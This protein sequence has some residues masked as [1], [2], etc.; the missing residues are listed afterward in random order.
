LGKLARRARTVVLYVVSIA[1]FVFAAFPVISMVLTSLKP[2]TEIMK[3][4]SSLLDA[5]IPKN[6]TL[7]AYERVLFEGT[8][9]FGVYYNAEFP[10]WALH[11]LIVATCVT[12]ITMVATIFGGYGFARFNFR[13][14]GSLK[15][16]ILMFYLLPEVVL[17]VPLFIMLRYLGILNTYYAMIFTY[18]SNCI[19]LAMWLLI[20]FFI[21][22]PVELEEAGMV[23]GCSRLG[24]LL[25]IVLPI[26]L[27]GIAAVGILTFSTALE[28]F[29]FAYTFADTD[30]TRVINVGIYRYMGEFG[31]QWADLMAA[32]VLTTILIVVLFSYAQKYIVGGFT[33][34]ALK[35]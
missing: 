14:S 11:S 5:L 7:G 23:D 8:T 30:A 3:L 24:S 27:P 31:T 12:A 17:L 29:L 34:G 1:L 25:R 16:S 6:P 18:L 28:E 10:R 19:P 35:G 22:S 13:F 20:G 21:T 15:L 2:E 4:H 33:A 32:A 26:N 9:V